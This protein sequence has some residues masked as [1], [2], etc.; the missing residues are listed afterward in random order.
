MEPPGYQL[1]WWDAQARSL[2]SHTAFIGNS[3]G[4]IRSMTVMN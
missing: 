4:R 1:H 3:M 2:V